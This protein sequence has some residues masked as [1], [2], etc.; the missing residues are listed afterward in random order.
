MATVNYSYDALS[1]G[2]IRR[3][4]VAML[5]NNAK[6]GMSF[7]YQDFKKIDGKWYCWFRSELRS[8]DVLLVESGNAEKQEV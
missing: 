2:S 8:D 5:K 6:H 4:R 1:A 3:L 7:E